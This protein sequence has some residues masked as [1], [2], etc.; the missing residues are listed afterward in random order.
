[1]CRSLE[2]LLKAACQSRRFARYQSYAIIAKLANPERDA[3]SLSAQR[4]G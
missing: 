1:M 3:E 4:N 2:A